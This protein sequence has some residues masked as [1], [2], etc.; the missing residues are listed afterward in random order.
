MATGL[1]PPI[2]PDISREFPGDFN[3][4]NHLE[5]VFQSDDFPK[6]PPPPVIP[7]IPNNVGNRKVE[8]FAR[9]TPDGHRIE[10]RV[11]TFSYNPPP[12]INS[13]SRTDQSA[14]GYQRNENILNDNRDVTGYRTQSFFKQQFRT[15]TPNLESN[16]FDQNNRVSSRNSIVQNNNNQWWNALNVL[17]NGNDNLN[18]SGPQINQQI[19]QN[20]NE[21]QNN[22]NRAFG[23]RLAG[24]RNGNTQGGFI[25]NRQ[26]T[27]GSQGNR[28]YHTNQ[29]FINPPSNQNFNNNPVTNSHA[30][31]NIP[32]TRNVHTQNNY[33]SVNNNAFPNVRNSRFGINNNRNNINAYSN[34]QAP[35]NAFGN[36]QTGNIAFNDDT[37]KKVMNL[38]QGV[39]SHLNNLHNNNP[40]INNIGPSWDEDITRNF[41]NDWSTRRRPF[42]NGHSGP[43]VSP[44][45]VDILKNT[46]D[47]LNGNRN[48]DIPRNQGNN[49]RNVDGG[50][51]EKIFRSDK[52]VEGPN[53][54][55]RNQHRGYERDFR[56][57]SDSG[58]SRSNQWST[59]TVRRLDA[60][61]SKP[62]FSKDFI[63]VFRDD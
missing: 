63:D 2:S 36:H 11:E 30:V 56:V 54:Y 32:F 55:S 15:M 40:R 24:F 12:V 60:Q 9:D 51:V 53:S 4:V 43:S 35:N 47:A 26:N 34:H 5:N 33:Q 25:N 3:S 50:G 59:N 17:R 48:I 18:P 27:F 28:N 6:I 41:D 39:T 7:N 45:P 10:G 14:E 23:A 38:I 8:N 20:I 42:S 37:E 19:N 21:I 22:I 1:L 44:G 61:S 52:I 16:G 57:N 49:Y 29:N 58:Y 46:F 62:D 31:P 13:V